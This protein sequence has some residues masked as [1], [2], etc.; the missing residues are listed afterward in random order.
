MTLIFPVGS[1]ALCLIAAPVFAAQSPMPEP[2]PASRYAKLIEKSPFS[3]ATP[4]APVAAPT[5]NFAA[6]LVVDGISGE[7]GKERVTIKVRNGDPVKDTFTLVG[8]E[9]NAEGIAVTGIE[10]PDSW[11]ET[12]VTLKKGTEFGSVKYDK[13]GAPAQISGSVAPGGQQQRL[14]NGMVAPGNVQPGQNTA[15]GVQKNLNRI[16]P[17]LPRPTTVQPAA[18]QPGVQKPAVPGA[19]PAGG[20]EPRRRVRVINTKP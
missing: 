16:Q 13:K 19:L 2:F 12:A 5:A 3:V 11:T 9:P 7:K 10:A 4:V 18:N 17:I 15:G 6:N 8:N 14:P 1:C 20:V